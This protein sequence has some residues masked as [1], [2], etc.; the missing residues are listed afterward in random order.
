MG[1]SYLIMSDIHG[2]LSALQRVLADG[3]PEEREGIL[4]LGDMIDYGPQS[5][6]VVEELEKIDKSLIVVNLWGNHEYAFFNRDYTHFSSKRGVESAM[7]T[8]SVLNEDNACYLEGMDRSGIR[9]FFLEG[10]RC[11]AVHG[12]LNDCFWKSITPGELNGEYGIYDFVFSGH[13]HV[14]HAFT[15]FYHTD[16]E[17]YR[18]RKAVHFINPG[19]VGQ[20]RNHNPNAQYAVFDIATG[21]V[22][23]KS[24]PYDIKHV[25]SMLSGKGNEFYSRRLETGI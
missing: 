18:N 6:E 2:N 5:N 11:L 24:V 25:Q 12:S 15:W 9:D 19:S 14:S 22:E 7:Y 8:A 10:K 4:I 13:S 23:L 16:C 17:K 21:A 1:H 3:R 20:P